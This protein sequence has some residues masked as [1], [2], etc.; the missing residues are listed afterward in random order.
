VTYGL[1]GTTAENP[2]HELFVVNN[3][4]VN[5]RTAGSTFISV[6]SA[7]TTPIVIINN[8]FF[9]GGTITTQSGATQQ[10]NFAQGD[11]LLIN[12]AAFDYRLAPGSPCINAGSDP[13]TGAG[14][15]LLPTRQYVH[16][17]SAVDRT[18]MGAVDIGAYE[19]GQAM[20]AGADDADAGPPPDARDSGSLPPSDASDARP[21]PDASDADAARLPDASDGAARRDAPDGG[22]LFDASVGPDATPPLDAAEAGPTPMPDASDAGVPPPPGADASDSG[23]CGCR[24]A[25]GL[26]TPSPFIACAAALVAA[27]RRRTRGRRPGAHRSARPRASAVAGPPPPVCKRQQPASR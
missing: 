15:A 11:P 22:A 19:F 2:G 12:R 21:A 20:D 8:I 10:T 18:S 23:G 6:G 24:T 4:F 3:T 7:I 14:F 25:R 5:D 1:E 17:V 27:L 26:D 16:S 9:G 13:G